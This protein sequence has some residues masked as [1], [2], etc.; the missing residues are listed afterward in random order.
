MAVYSDAHLSVDFETRTVL[1]D[2]E[3]LPLTRKEYE[4]AAFLVRY[5]GELIPRATLLSAVWGY[6]EG[7]RTRTLDAHVARLRARLGRY[8]VDYIETVFGRG[9]R[10]RPYSGGRAAVAAL[11][12]SA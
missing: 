8:S 11:A 9:Y 10:F 5:A 4:L 2:G 3:R 7:I 6:S 1:L 12:L